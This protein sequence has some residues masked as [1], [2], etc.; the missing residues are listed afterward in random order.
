MSPAGSGKEISHAPTRCDTAT[1][2]P[3]SLLWWGLEYHNDASPSLLLLA[4]PQIINWMEEA[5][6]MLLHLSSS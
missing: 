1:W 5:T 6:Q 2:F 3:T 4:Y